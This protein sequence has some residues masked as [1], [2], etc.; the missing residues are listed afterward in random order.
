MMF[1][2]TSVVNHYECELIGSHWISLNV[3]DNNITYFDRF[4]VGHIIYICYL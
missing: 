2:W 1:V 3:N 4:G